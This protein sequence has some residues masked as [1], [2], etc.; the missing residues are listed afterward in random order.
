M[1]EF[2]MKACMIDISRFRVAKIERMK[3]ML[4]NLAETGYD[5]VFFNIEHTFKVPELPRIGFEADGYDI[6]QFKDINEFASS[7]GLK[8]VP[9]IQS[10]GH[11]FHILKWKEFDNISESDMKWSVSLSDQTYALI[12]K[13]YKRASE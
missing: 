8:L 4:K 12:D 11:M 9:L 2:R 1:T 5:T 7:I 6:G 10:F 13:L 3:L